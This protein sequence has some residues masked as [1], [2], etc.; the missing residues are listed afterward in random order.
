MHTRGSGSEVAVVVP[1][2]ADERGDHGSA[3]EFPACQA[4]LSRPAPKQ[5]LEL[6][7]NLQSETVQK[8]R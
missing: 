2:L 1:L 3:T 4:L 7:K 8:P 6:D 5:I